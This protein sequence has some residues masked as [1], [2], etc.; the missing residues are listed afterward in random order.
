MNHT[1]QDHTDRDLLAKILSPHT[2]PDQK[3]EALNESN[4]RASK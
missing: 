1:I 4:R 2:T 3:R